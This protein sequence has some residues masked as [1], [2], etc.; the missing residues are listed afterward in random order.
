MKRFSILILAFIFGVICCGCV[1]SSNDDYS[2]STESLQDEIAILE[3]E[4]EE[5]TQRIE[6]LEYQVEEMQNT[7]W[8]IEDYLSGGY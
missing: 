4:N 7:I 3:S 8:N 2:P 6:D 5:L 1:S